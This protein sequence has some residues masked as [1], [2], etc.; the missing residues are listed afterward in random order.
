[1]ESLQNTSY[2]VIHLTLASFREAQQFSEHII[3]YEFEYIPE[4]QLL[5]FVPDSTCACIIVYACVEAIVIVYNIF[6][7][8]ADINLYKN[9]KSN[10][11]PFI[12]Y[13]SY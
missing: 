7:H 13:K 6:H 1:M 2:P 9:G 4:W 5:F 10:K 12:V 11:F 3:Y 8:N